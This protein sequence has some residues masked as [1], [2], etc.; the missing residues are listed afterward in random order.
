MQDV[1]IRIRTGKFY[2]TFEA[3]D[4]RHFP[5]LNLSDPHNANLIASVRKANPV[6]KMYLP[7]DTI[8]K[9]AASTRLCD[10]STCKFGKSSPRRG[11]PI[12]AEG[13]IVFAICICMRRIF[14]LN[15]PIRCTSKQDQ[16]RYKMWLYGYFVHS[17]CS[18]NIAD[19]SDSQSDDSQEPMTQAQD[20]RKLYRVIYSGYLNS[21]VNSLH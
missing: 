19:S 12:T 17:G 7:E 14:R 8:E 13:A 5:V 20:G 10:L 21:A 3:L 18:N 16:E 1:E 11:H 15:M 4:V 2:L 9:F 6:L